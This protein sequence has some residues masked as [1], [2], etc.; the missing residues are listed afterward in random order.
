MLKASPPG[1]SS[2]YSVMN[3]APHV[4]TRKSSPPQNLIRQ[5]DKEAF[6]NL[7]KME[8]LMSICVISTVPRFTSYP[9]LPAVQDLCFLVLQLSTVLEF[10][11]HFISS[12]SWC[13]MY[14]LK[15]QDASITVLDG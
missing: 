15:S 5:C 7:D 4:L 8:L 3:E 9:S 2:L 1:R 6:G 14:N 13:L 11:S 12:H 10:N